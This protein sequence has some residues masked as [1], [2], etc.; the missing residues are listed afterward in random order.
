MYN[1]QK[2]ITKTNMELKRRKQVRRVRTWDFCVFRGCFYKRLKSAK[3]GTVSPRFLGRLTPMTSAGDGREKARRTGR[4]AEAGG[5]WGARRPNE[6][7]NR[8]VRQGEASTVHHSLEAIALLSTRSG[9][10]AAAEATLMQNVCK[11]RRDTACPVIDD[12]SYYNAERRDDCL[13]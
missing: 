1:A 13:Q 10:A 12:P 3:S 4:A 6:W 11:S 5:D 9:P 2:V 8:P 7:V